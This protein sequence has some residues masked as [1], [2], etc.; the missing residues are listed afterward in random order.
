MSKFLLTEEMV[1]ICAKRAVRPHSIYINDEVKREHLRHVAARGT[2]HP[3]SRGMV[4]RRLR[5][6]AAKDFLSESAFPDGNYGYEWAIRE[7]IKYT[8]DNLADVLAFT[9]KH[10]KWDEWFSSFEDYQRHVDENGSR[11]LLLSDD[12]A[13]SAAPGDWIIKHPDGCFAVVR[14][15]NMKSCR[16]VP[17]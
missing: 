17:K 14:S 13:R 12:G 6:L 1:L 15:Y 16:G 10:P 8:G 2:G 7:S 5:S 4:L 9:G 11:F 3:P